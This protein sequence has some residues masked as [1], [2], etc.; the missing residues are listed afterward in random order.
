MRAPLPC[1]GL[2]PLRGGGWLLGG[3]GKHL[4]PATLL[5]T[6]SHQQ[7]LGG[8]M[9]RRCSNCV[10]GVAAALG[11]DAGL[12]DVKSALGWMGGGCCSQ[13]RDA[14]RLWE[15]ASLRT[16]PAAAADTGALPHVPPPRSG[17]QPALFLTPSHLF[18][19]MVQHRTGLTQLIAP[20]MG[21]DGTSLAQGCSHLCC[22]STAPALRGSRHV[23][24]PHAWWG[25]SQE[26]CCRFKTKQ[27]SSCPGGCRR[28][29]ST[30]EHLNIWSK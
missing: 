7:G 29:Q 23:Q 9:A 3:H 22:G 19:G 5:H 21:S 15:Q 17:V 12:E 16:L 6:A 1:A 20:G 28:I 13:N 11:R 24:S 18:W 2:A 25:V 14:P 27:F 4:P 30:D 10:P 26:L 8:G